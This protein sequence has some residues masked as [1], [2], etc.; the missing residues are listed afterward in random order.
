ADAERRRLLDD[1][2]P[3]AAGLALARPALRNRAAI[4]ADVGAAF[5]HEVRRSELLCFSENVLGFVAAATAGL[6]AAFRHARA[7]PGH[8]RR[9]VERPPPQ[10]S[11]ST[12]GQTSNSAVAG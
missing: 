3:L 4:L 12:V 9:S 7:C 10:G 2:V 1:G 5:G 8:P 6:D 11:R